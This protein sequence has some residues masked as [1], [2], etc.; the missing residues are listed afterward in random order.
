MIEISLIGVEEADITLM[1]DEK[2]CFFS[3]PAE[4]GLEY[5]GTIPFLREVT[6][7]GAKAAYVDSFLKIEVPFKDTLENFI[8][9]PVE[10]IEEEEDAE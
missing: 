10:A 5:V 6:P 3:A 4:G 2:G 8:Q 9:V 1:M 7:S